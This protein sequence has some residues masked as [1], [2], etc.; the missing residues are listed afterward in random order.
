MDNQ[1]W[2]INKGFGDVLTKLI[3]DVNTAAQQGNIKEWFNNLRVLYRNIAGHKKVSK[4]VIELLDKEFKI[5]RNK[6]NMAS[7]VT[8]QGKT[9]HQVLENEI[10][11]ILDEINIKI[12]SEMHQAGL[13]LPI[14]KNMPEY[15][16]LEM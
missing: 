15:A 3:V 5:V 7:P 11:D 12:I 9:Y 16:T 1:E 14:H 2:N 10:K 4:D 8:R 13:I 6:M